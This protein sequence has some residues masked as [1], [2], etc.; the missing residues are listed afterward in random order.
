[1]TSARVVEE[2]VG[3]LLTPCARDRGLILR[4]SPKRA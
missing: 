3:L 4:R 1:L 2:L